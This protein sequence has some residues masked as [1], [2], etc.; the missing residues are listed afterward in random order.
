[1]RASSR[2]RTLGRPVAWV[3]AGLVVALALPVDAGATFPGRN[4]LIAFEAQRDTTTDPSGFCPTY[5]CENDRVQAVSPRSGRLVPVGICSAYECH[6]SSPSWSPRGGALAFD[7]LLPGHVDEDERPTP[8]RYLI[9][10]AHRDGSRLRTV[11]EPGINPI[12]SPDGDQLIFQRKTPE[13]ESL[14]T[15]TL[16]DMVLVRLANG[17]YAD[18]SSRGVVALTRSA[19]GRRRP[20]GLDL[21]TI[22]P[23]SRSGVRRITFGGR[24]SNPS[25]APDGRRLAFEHLGRRR[26]DI[27]VTD[28]RGTPGDAS[29]QEMPSLLSGLRMESGSRL[30]AVRASTSPRPMVRISAR[31]TPLRLTPGSST[32]SRI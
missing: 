32:P 20:F 11:Y 29:S 24:A 8:D 12:W 31:S 27:A 4:G 18:W 28:T 25:W 17:F 21:F 1:M 22:R 26:I 3:S 7:R 9:G 10:I 6:D 23:D 19:P 15:L 13:D 16:D 30:C 14:Y 2:L 5:E